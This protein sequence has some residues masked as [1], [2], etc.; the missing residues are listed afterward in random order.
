MNLIYDKW[1]PVRRKSGKK[2]KIAPWQVTENMV[3]DPIVELAALRPD[4]NGA[5]IQFLIGLLQTTCAPN[6]NK[7]WRAWRDNPPAPEE[8][9]RKFEEVAFAFNL[10]GDGPRFMQDLMLEKETT[11]TKET[12]E[13]LFLDSPGEKTLK[14]NT[15]HFVKRERMEKLCLSCAAQA[16]LT[17]QV[18]APA[19]GKGHRVGLRGGGPVT[20]IIYEDD[21]WQTAWGNVL[22]QDRFYGLANKNK[23]ENKDKF[24][25]CDTTR[26]SDNDRATTALDIH[27]VQIYWSIPRR[28]RLL[29]DEQQGDCD[30]CGNA[31]VVFT[32]YLTKPYG[33]MYK[34]ILHPLT[35][36]YHNAQNEPLPAHQHEIIGYKYWLGYA[37]AVPDGK[38][39]PAEII[40]QIISRRLNNFRLWAFGYDMDNMKACCWYEGIMPVVAIEDD[41]KRQIYEAEIASIIQASDSIVVSLRYAVKGAWFD[42]QQKKNVDLG[43]VVQRFW[44][45]TEPDFYRHIEQMRKDIMADAD[46][47]S[48]KQKWHKCIVRKAEQI[49]DE[50]SQSGMIDE[51]NVKRVADSWNKL[52]RNIYGKKIKQDILGLPS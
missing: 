37:Q 52:R 12:I 39:Q 21:L 22:D 44:Q 40:N 7:E 1:I 20:T 2:E 42:P 13:K 23:E 27:P 14:F 11:K 9:K 46:G 50:V 41:A 38:K 6:G 10:D 17:L 51:V 15:D 4:F 8:L 31:E 33:V 26:T 19:G 29:F 28:I 3:A 18:N 45:E 32:E 35:P 5:L 43:F 49:F 48:V 36:I 34:N 25:W 24:P 16:L 30:L 47:L